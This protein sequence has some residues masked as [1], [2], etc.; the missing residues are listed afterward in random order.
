[1]NMYVHNTYLYAVVTLRGW[2]LH[3]DD[4]LIICFQKLN[5]KSLECDTLG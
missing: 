3:D 1:M 2:W 5:V 4:K